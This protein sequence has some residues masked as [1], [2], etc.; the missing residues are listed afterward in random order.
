LLDEERAFARFEGG[1]ILCATV[2]AELVEGSRVVIANDDVLVV[3][4]FWAGTPYELLVIPREHTGH[5]QK[6]SMPSTTATGLAI[7]DALRALAALQGDVAFNVVF[8]TAPH[9][10]D[11]PFHWHAHVW[12][13]LVTIAGFERGTGVLINIVP[14]EHAASD[15]RQRM[16]VG[17]G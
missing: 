9:H 10:H 12:P 7:R 13:K 17:A 8:H 6:A 14:P 16:P 2:E 1:C 5:L 3:S 4:P 11:G 15:L